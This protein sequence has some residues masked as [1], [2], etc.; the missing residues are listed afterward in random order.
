MTL[1]FQNLYDIEGLPSSARGICL[2]KHNLDKQVAVSIALAIHHN[3]CIKFFFLTYMLNQN[4]SVSQMK[5]C[6]KRKRIL[7]NTNTLKDCRKRKRILVNNI[8]APPTMFSRAFF[9][10]DCGFSS[11]CSS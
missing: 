11:I 5:D 7:V 3:G 9:I 8:S 6:R 2:Y 1:P 10:R 4:S